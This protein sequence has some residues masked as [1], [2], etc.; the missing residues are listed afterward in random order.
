MKLLVNC[1]SSIAALATL[2]MTS[3]SCTAAAPLDGLTIGSNAPSLDI[4]H[5]LQ[6]GKSQLPK[7]K[8]FEKD[9][10]YVIEFWATWCGPC[11]QS[12]PHLAET[13][14]KYASKGLQI[15]SVS[16]E[17]LDEVKEFLDRKVPGKGSLTFGELTNEYSLTADPD[18]STSRDY[19]DAA[20]K[21][22]IPCA[23]IVGRDAKI[24]W[25][26][27]PFEMD[28]PLSEIL[29]GKW[30]R[31]AFAQSYQEAQEAE[32]LI[33]EVERK[34]GA[35]LNKKK[36]KEALELLD[37]YI[38]KVKPIP[39]KF[40]LFGNK[41]ELQLRAKSDSKAI[42][43]TL[44]SMLTTFAEEPELIVNTSWM[45]YQAFEEGTIDSKSIV[46]RAAQA[47]T[48]AIKSLGD[49]NKG[50]GLDILAHLKVTLGDVPGALASGNEALKF[51][52]AEESKE[53]RDFLKGLEPKQ[54]KAK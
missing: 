43:L 46:K 16:T 52:G 39:L 41:I 8:K 14:K 30:D 29:D 54:S 37:E 42:A 35:L 17:T 7:V 31:A 2:I 38:A 28:E 26:G 44:D 34:I 4:E 51:L 40:Q 13:Q 25:I 45:I 9:K 3:V 19:M 5:W 23:F 18:M 22:A 53:L 32:E 1:V 49:A 24:E 10:V 11:V 27:S 50:T 20:K 12:M 48:T 47:T 6:T 21:N 15:V 33:S 36:S